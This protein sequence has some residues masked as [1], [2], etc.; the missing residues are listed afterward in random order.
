MNENVSTNEVRKTYFITSENEVVYPAGAWRRIFARLIDIIFI[1]IIPFITVLIYSSIN[2]NS[3][4]SVA[5]SMYDGWVVGIASLQIILT[6]IFF[7]V[8]PMTNR[9]YFGQSLGKRIVKI[10]PMY[11]GENK[12]SSFLIRESIIS[13]LYLLPTIMVVALGYDVISI[14]SGYINYATENNIAIEYS[15]VYS[16]I[17]SGW[18]N[19]VDANI[20]LVDKINSVQK[21]LLYASV[22]IQYICLIMI[23]FIAVTIGIEFQKRGFH[24]KIANTSVI[25]LKTFTSLERVTK[26]YDEMLNINSDEK[27]IKPEVLD[28]QNSD[29]IELSEKEITIS[30]E[31][32]IDYNKMTIPQ[33]KDELIKRNINFKTS[34]RKKELIELLEKNDL[35]NE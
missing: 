3:D 18:N 19:L 10:T 22:I 17:F 11:L 27:D 30:E 21:G 35:E 31:N 9:K 20:Y 33:L 26:E 12:Y 28:E 14:Y 7:I 25:D 13:G 16:F 29:P 24:D 32:K 5:P 4:V 2:G 15:N 23:I 6:I 34:S 8:I 1:S